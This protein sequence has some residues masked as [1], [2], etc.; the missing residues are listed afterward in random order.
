MPPGPSPRMLCKNSAA[1]VQ[2][3]CPSTC[4]LQSS[5]LQRRPNKT[6]DTILQLERRTL[7][8]IHQLP[9]WY[10]SAGV[11][12][13]AGI[14]AITERIGNLQRRYADRIIEAGPPKDTILDVAPHPNRN[15]KFKYRHPPATLLQKASRLTPQRTE[16][17]DRIPLIYR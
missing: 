8:R 16:A 1:H 13:R 15:P 9:P 5:Y 12:N 3:I 10:P 4:R 2:N 11:H 17:L 7:R 6:A 14:E